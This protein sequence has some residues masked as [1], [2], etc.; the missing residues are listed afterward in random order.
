MK[1]VIF[2]SCL[3]LISIS[4]SAQIPSHVPQNGLIGYWP[5][6]GNANDIS[7]NGLNGVVTGATLTNDRFNEPNSA[8]FF[9]GNGDQII[10]PASINF[11]SNDLT[12]AFWVKVTTQTPYHQIQFATSTNGHLSRGF[13]FSDARIAYIPSLS[14]CSS[15]G[16]VGLSNFGIQTDVWTNLAFTINQNR[17]ILYINGVSKDTLLSGPVACSSI[18]QMVLG[19][20]IAGGGSEW[21]NGYFDEVGIWNRELSAVEIAA[22]YNHPQ[23]AT[24][25]K[26]P[27][28]KWVK[29]IGGTTNEDGQAISN[30]SSGSVFVTGYYSSSPISFGSI[31]VP[32]PNS[33]DIFVAKYDKKGNVNWVKTFGGSN[34][35]NYISDNNQVA[36]LKCANIASDNNGN[37]YVSGSYLSDTL[38]IGTSILPNSGLGDFFL[39][40]FDNNGNLLWAK[41]GGGNDFDYV[42]GLTTDLNGNVIISGRF[43]SSSIT[44]GSTTLVNSGGTDAFI[45]KY[46]S[47]GNVLWAKRVGGTGDEIYHSVTSDFNNNIYVTGWYNSTSLSVGSTTLANSGGKDI[48]LAKYD[49]NGNVIWAKKVGGIGDEFSRSIMVDATGNILIGGGFSTTSLTVGTNVLSNSGGVDIL[50][51][52]Y[53]ASGNV[54]SSKKAGGIGD[55]TITKLSKNANGKTLM[56]GVFSSSDLYLDTNKLTNFGGKD[57]FF[58]ETDNNGNFIWAKK[59]GGAN[60]DILNDFSVDING[61]ANLTGNFNSP[62]I[63]FDNAN[64]SNHPLSNGLI[65]KDIFIANISTIYNN[66]IIQNQVTCYNS[67]PNVISGTDKV[68][69]NASYKWIQAHANLIYTDAVGINNLKDYQPSNLIETNWY[70]RVIQNGP[71]KDTSNAIKIEVIGKPISVIKVNNKNQCIK[72]NQFE[73]IDSSKV[74]G[75]GTI[76]QNIWDFGDGTTSLDKNPIKT[77]SQSGTYNVKLRVFTNYLCSDSSVLQVKVFENQTTKISFDKTTQCLLD[78]SFILVDSTT[79]TNGVIA[80]RVWDF[81]DSTQSTIK[82]PIKNYSKSGQYTIKLLTITDNGCIDSASISVNILNSPNVG[83]IVGQANNLLLNTPYNYIVNQQLSHN[84]EWLVDNGVIASGQGTNSLSV[85]WL[86]NGQSS[87]KCILTNSDNCTDTAVLNVNIGTTGINDVKNS[88]IKIYPNPTNNII[89]IEGL[90]KNEN[91]TIQ[92]FDVQGKLVITKTITEKGTIDLSELNK[93]VYVIK[94]GEV[95]QRIVKM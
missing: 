27:N 52:K 33:Y 72:F 87:L 6:N 78:N 48:L 14:D 63:S 35:E 61:N 40:K 89:N 91:N 10:T 67:T 4:A 7:G 19:N 26:T 57:I 23:I 36:E 82:N 17:T 5:I 18:M 59:I 29:G 37:I 39:A 32:P 11:A 13:A 41:K 84:Y 75:N 30:D 88:N 1:K 21:F 44:F 20:D 95:A 86:A 2:H 49:A 3:L 24:F 51:V 28:Y 43:S 42:F 71:F 76:G 81:G 8:Y 54:I 69:T 94:I 50:I 74:V 64:V 46:S 55:E 79:L 9:D 73:F 31:Q 93:G 90:N 65:F 22:F 62:T 56:G 80:S 15:P 25:T 12:I 85:L 68:I 38:L 92:I 45:V 83:S 47:S 16:I 60:D 58:S 66:E 77:Y 34:S 70:K 53:D